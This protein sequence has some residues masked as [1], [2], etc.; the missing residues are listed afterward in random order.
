MRTVSLWV[1]LRVAFGLLMVSI[2]FPA[3]AQ[4]NAKLTYPKA[5]KSDVVDV[6][7]G[8][9]VA[10]PYRWLE[11]TESDETALWIKAENEVTRS[12]LDGLPGRDALRTRLTELWN[13]ERFS[14]PVVRGA[15]YFYTRNDGL[16]NQSVLFVADGL[17]AP[18]RVLLDPNGLSEDGTIALAGWVPSD[19]GKLL[20]Y[21]LADGGSDWRTW[22]IRNIDTGE[23]LEDTIQWVKFSGAAWL[24]DGSGFYYGRYDAPEEG[25]ELTGTNKFQKLYFHRIGTSQSEDVLIYQR[26]DEPNWGFSPEVTED[27][28]YLIVSVWK[29]TEPVSQILVQDLREENA[30]VKPLLM[31]FDADYTFVAS[32]DDTLYFLTDLDAPRRRIVAVSAVEAGDPNDELSVKPTITE[33]IPQSDDVLQSISLLGDRFFAV[34]LKDARGLATIFS[35]DGAKIRDIEL[36]GVGSVAGFGGKRSASE[37]FYSFTNYVTPPSIYRYELGSDAQSLWRRPDVKF[38]SSL[39]ATE[40]VFYTSKDGTRVPMILSYRKGLELDGKNPTLLYAY[41]G[42]NIS[43]T[44]GFSP[45]VAGWLDAGG[46]YAVPNLRGGGEYGRDWHEAGML[47][48]K[49]NVFDDFIAAANYLID[50]KYTSSEHLGIRGGSNGGLLV[51]A[52]M[53]QRPDLFGA[54]LPAVGVMDM[55][56]FHKFTIGWAWVSEYG[57]S[58]DAE[59]FETLMKYSPLHTIKDGTCYPPTLVTTADRD[60]RV[61]P[62]HSFKFAARL[63]EAQGCDN[64]VLIRIE[65][66]AGHG[67]GTPVS[68]SIDEYTDLWSFLMANLAGN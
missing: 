42:F 45:A 41:G 65:T 48:R 38:D 52:V 22:K 36:P 68:K 55:L 1:H 62:G 17:D 33:V 57:S 18:R 59:Q 23:D 7:H 37:T 46:V 51:G 13:Y 53:T 29:G 27:G 12:Y 2:G 31:G 35:L 50:N 58:D 30:P 60:D 19:D 43:L 26:E 16:Q 6:Y 39:Y 14:A 49:Q 56:R 40:Q 24:P 64:P 67:A 8:V 28:R 11:D 63:Q 4:E 20:A 47:E 3:L 15:R 61:V 34:Y 21:G 10:D 54:C 9:E 25:K 44:P 32:G 66:R 5:E